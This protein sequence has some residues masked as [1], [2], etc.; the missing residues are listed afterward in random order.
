MYT[1]E[2][3]LEIW[4]TEKRI[5]ETFVV[6][7]AY[8]PAMIVVPARS[9]ERKGPRQTKVLSDGAGGKGLDEALAACPAL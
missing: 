2:G 4:L 5:E 1:F 9:S 3:G 7:R 6:F 8:F